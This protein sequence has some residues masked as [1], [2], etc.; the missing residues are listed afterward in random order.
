MQAAL[1]SYAKWAEEFNAC[2][3]VD[4]VA[5]ELLYR[6][7]LSAPVAEALQALCDGRSVVTTCSIA[8]RVV[9]IAGAEVRVGEPEGDVVYVLP[10]C[11]D[12]G[13]VTVLTPAC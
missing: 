7:P 9:E 8:E 6:R 2:S 12:P 11:D 10:S 1:Q 3:H 5:H 4:H 13:A